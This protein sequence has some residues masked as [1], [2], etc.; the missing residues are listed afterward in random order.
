MFLS[1][2]LDWKPISL[3]SKGRFGNYQRNPVY[4]CL[5][6]KG[7][8]IDLRNVFLTT[9]T[10]LEPMMIERADG[11]IKPFSTRNCIQLR[12]TPVKIN[13]FGTNN[14]KPSEGF[15]IVNSHQNCARVQDP[16]FAFV[17]CH[18]F[19]SLP[20]MRASSKRNN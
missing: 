3:G 15:L 7:G 2:F 6:S 1:T 16:Y 14:L 20:E 17:A 11:S 10:I 5:P 8:G 12:P 9:L 19:R 18:R 13:M 4:G